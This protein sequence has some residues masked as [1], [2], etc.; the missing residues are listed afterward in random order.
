MRK[1]QKSAERRRGTVIVVVCVLVALA[2]VGIAAVPI[3]KDKLDERELSNTALADLGS[4]ASACEKITTKKAEGNQ[5]HVPVGTEVDYP[6]S[7]PAFGK[8]WN[9]A[10][11][12]P[13]PFARKFYTTEDRPEI[14]ALVHNLEHGYTILWYDET[15]ADDDDALADV[16]AIAEKF[17]GDSLRDKFIAA[18]WQKSDDDEGTFPEG[19]HVA[20]THWSAGGVGETDT[21]KQVGVWQYCSAPSG[22]AVEDFVKKYPYFDSPEPDAM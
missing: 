21:T 17:D 15:I 16:Q 8:H 3:I 19:Q 22:E 9:E 14:E 2:I 12:A 1:K 5:E 18:P 7:P 20:L 6:D 10:G 4:A 13:A 11:V